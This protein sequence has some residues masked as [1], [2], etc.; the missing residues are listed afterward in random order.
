M[1]LSNILRKL[2]KRKLEPPEVRQRGSNR[3]EELN[4]TK[5]K[6]PTRAFASSH[7]GAY[8]PIEKNLHRS[9]KDSHGGDYQPNQYQTTSSDQRTDHGGDYRPDFTNNNYSA[10]QAQQP[11]PTSRRG[12]GCPSRSKRRRGSR[13]SLGI[14]FIQKP[15]EE[16]NTYQRKRNQLFHHRDIL[17]RPYSGLRDIRFLNP[18]DGKPTKLIVQS[19]EEVLANR[20]SADWERKSTDN[21]GPWIF[22]LTHWATANGGRSI[23]V[24]LPACAVL[25]IVERYENPPYKNAPSRPLI[26]QIERVSEP[27]YLCLVEDMKII[28]VQQW[29]KANGKDVALDYIMVSYTSKQFAS[30]NYKDKESLHAIGQRAAQ[31]ADVRAYWVGCSCL[32]PEDELEENV[33]R[34]SDVIKGAFQMVI[35]IAGPV[36]VEEIG[37]LPTEL[38]SQWGDRMWTL[39]E[40]LLSP[41][42]DIEIYT[43]NRSHD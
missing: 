26:G 7:T 10:A 5:S 11:N 24:W 4:S 22:R 13:S 31:A 14:L 20:S 30:N 25:T 27:P 42:R 18:R 39:P 32:G 40:L 2:F 12:L 38:L 29:R 21:A 35:A 17:K 16:A 28:D 9:V 23:V 6:K 8:D 37:T 33:W 41:E 3:G 19:S 34:I 36:D 15:L 1:G 43:L